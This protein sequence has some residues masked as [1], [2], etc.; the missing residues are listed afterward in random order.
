MRFFF[1]KRAILAPAILAET[2][3]AQAIFSQAVHCSRVCRGFVSAKISFAFLVSRGHAPEDGPL[4][5]FPQGGCKFLRGPR[6]PSEKWPTVQKA[7]GRWRPGEAVEVHSTQARQCPSSSREY[8]SNEPRNGFSE[9]KRLSTKLSRRELWTKRK[10][11][12][13]ERRLALLQ[14]EAAQP[15]PLGTTSVTKLQQQ[16]DVLVRERDALRANPHQD[17]KWTGHGPPCA[18]NIPVMPT[19]IQELHGWLSDRKCELRNAME[20]GDAELV[21]KIG[22]LVGQGAAQLGLSGR[23][24]DVPMDGARSALMSSLIDEQTKRRCFG[25]GAGSALATQS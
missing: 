24:R 4:S 3:L 19:N 8:F 6:P 13:G 14:A 23:N 12:K 18:E 1:R 2:I 15:E 7:I 25:P 17:G 5:T 22:G 20:F 11:P 16:I 10:L 21:A 9:P